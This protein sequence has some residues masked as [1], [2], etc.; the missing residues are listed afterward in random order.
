VKRRIFAKLFLIFALVIA[1]TTAVL[2][3]SFRHSLEGPLREEIQRNLTQKTHLFALRAEN[4]HTH[5]PQEIVAQ[6]AQ[7]AGA[8]ATIMDLTG[9]VLADSEADASAMEN[10]ASR[11]EFAAALAGNVGSDERLSHTLGVPFLYVAAPIPGGAV[12]LAYPLSELQASMAT[13]RR[14]LIYSSALALVVSLVIAF[15][16]ALYS[17][18]RLR[19]IVSFA[20]RIADGDLTARISELAPDEIG[21]VADALNRT[22]LKLQEGFAALQTSQHRLETLLNSM[23]DAVIAVSED[24]R[25]LWANHGMGKLIP[26]KV[27]LGS[28]LVESVRDPDFLAAVREAVETRE[29]VTARAASILPGHTF[30]VTAAPMP[31]GGAVVVLRDLTER[32]RVE[33]T[34]RDFI[35]NV[36]HEL[37]TPLTSI[38]GYTETLLDSAPQNEAVREFLEIIRKNA[39]RMSRLTEDLLTLARVE[40]GEHQFDLE[41]V[42][43]DELLQDAVESFR[44]LSRAQG[45]ELGVEECAPQQVLADREAIHQ[46]FS[47]LIE[48]ASK[49]AAA[50]KRIV[51]AARST[52][53]GIEF[54]VRDYGPGISSEHVPRL[55]ERFYRV[56]K[57]R[58]RESGGTGLGLAIAKHIVLAHHGTI[59][60]ESE[61]NHGSAFLFTL[62]FA[63]VEVSPD[64]DA[65]SPAAVR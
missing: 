29:A 65:S 51:L 45:I 36:S 1:I 53:T 39:A 62:P 15:L 37:R 58:S 48:N 32:E 34:R 41:P 25:V 6:E 22:A 46:V 16:A 50:G 52:P 64:R 12:R 38:Q 13:V 54:S 11:K 55:F 2:D 19:R 33:K 44:E 63:S 4:D 5:S 20:D 40:S 60:A 23:Q 26:Q 30:D 27:R 18:R 21:Q 43:P 59:R 28:P 8:R 42:T 49:Y 9:K 14:Q 17:A 56:D 57:A 47:N 31:E 10:H 3:L 24:G 61:L 7:A 35:A